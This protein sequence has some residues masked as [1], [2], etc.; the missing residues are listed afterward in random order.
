MSIAHKNDELTSYAMLMGSH[1]RNRAKLNQDS[2]TI[3][4]T[5]NL[6]LR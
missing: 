5:T 6:T 2:A 3:D 4:G 1:C